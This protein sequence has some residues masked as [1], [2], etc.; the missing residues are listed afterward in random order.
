MEL[1][2]ILST[3][4]LA[5]WVYKLHGRVDALENSQA[6][7]NASKLANSAK[8]EPEVMEDDGIDRSNWPAH[9]QNKAQG[10]IKTAASKTK[11]APSL[12][13]EPFD[14]ENFLGRK[15][16]PIL[17]A[18]SIVVAIGF[19][20]LW[21][22]SNGW[23]GPMG[24]ITIGILVSLGLVGLG[25]YLRPRY[26]DFYTSVSA[27][28]I[29]GLII[30]TLL[31]HYVYDFIN[32]FQSLTLLALQAGVGVMLALRYDSRILANFSIAA[33]L[34]APWFTG[35]LE[36]ML[37]LPFILIIS[38]AGFAIATQKK[39]PEIFVSLIV[40]ASSYIFAALE[41][42]NREEVNDLFGAALNP[43]ANP[44]DPLLLLIFAAVIYTLIGSAG[45]VRLILNRKENKPAD[46]DVIE[47]VLFSI[48]LLLFNI[49]ALGVFYSQ[50]WSHIGFLILPQALILLAL[51]DWFKSQ[52]WPQFHLLSLSSSLLFILLATLWEL[53]DLNP[54]IL[55]IVLALE[56]AFMCAVGQLSQ[57]KTYE[58]FG[59]GALIMA[60]FSFVSEND[61]DFMTELLGTLV[62]VTAFVYSV[63][64]PKKVIEKIWLGLCLF[65]STTLIFA[66]SF[67]SDVIPT[68]L[69][70]LLPAVWFFHVL[71]VAY[72]Q[73]SLFL[74]IAAALIFIVLAISII[75]T[76]AAINTLS[77]FITWLWIALCG[78]FLYALQIQSGRDLIINKFI[79]Y[80]SLVVITLSWLI[81]TSDTLTEPLITLAWLALA[82]L[83][84]TL[85]SVQ[86]KWF[87]LRHLSLGIMLLIIAKLYLIDIWQWDTPVR[88]MAFTAL[89][90]VLLSMGFVYQKLWL[91]K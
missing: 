1:L 88:V 29:A 72:R 2:W 20:S 89:G 53:R 54:I 83:F 56:G 37:I 41:Q 43:V 17:G 68:L 63:G 42:L 46:E 16:F 59:R 25:E 57:Q 49:C 7:P 39:W 3:A 77:P 87:E 51:A 8:T 80:G 18:T 28:G 91:K 38:L 24:R 44:V 10:V 31:A 55:T 86:T 62:L 6:Q 21:A 15:L 85:G 75:E 66:I 23:V 19:F 50:D 82:A 14:L 81:R 64:K 12:I 30:T 11:A 47:I 40:F 5:Y 84:M 71:F 65:I 76:Y 9:L 70:P 4:A 74:R 26:P 58:W 78:G 60:F 34:L 79:S 52:E 73:N 69:E 35:E 45:I 32:S 61:Y 27:A 48:A 67:N 36:P 33:G 22:F 90:L 13:A